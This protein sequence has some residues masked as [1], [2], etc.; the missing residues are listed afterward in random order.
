M[1]GA[2]RLACCS[3][4][5]ASVPLD[6]FLSPCHLWNVPGQEEMG[7]DVLCGMGKLVRKK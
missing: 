1:A 2:S 3:H 7:K 6:P 5:S 4:A